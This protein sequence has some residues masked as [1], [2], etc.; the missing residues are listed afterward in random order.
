[1]KIIATRNGY[2]IFLEEQSLEQMLDETKPELRLKARHTLSET[3][4]AL[5]FFMSAAAIA[6]MSASDDVSPEFKAKINVSGEGYVVTFCTDY[7]KGMSTLE[8]E[9]ILQHELGHIESGILDQT[10]TN[11]RKGALGIVDDVENEILADRHAAERVGAATMYSALVKVLGNT[12]DMFCRL[13]LSH[14]DRVE[15]IRAAL[16][17]NAQSVRRLAALQSLMD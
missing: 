2:P 8:R 16:L 4:G 10:Q 7:F 13:R 14:R 9:A 15:E 1:M 3:G 6:A 11:V 12:A 17:G 5:A